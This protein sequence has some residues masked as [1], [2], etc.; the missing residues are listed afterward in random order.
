M[1][2]ARDFSDGGLEDNKYVV[3]SAKINDHKPV[4]LNIYRYLTI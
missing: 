4:A 2:H 1:E 3:Y